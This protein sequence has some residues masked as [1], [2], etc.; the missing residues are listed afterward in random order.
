MH[1]WLCHRPQQA[2]PTTQTSH[3]WSSMSIPSFCWFL[4]T[5]GSGIQDWKPHLCQGSILPYTWSSKKLSNKFL[6]LMKSLHSWHPFC[7]PTTSGQSPCCTPSFPH[8]NVEPALQIQFTPANCCQWWT[9]IWNLRNPWLQDW[10]PTSCLQAIVSCLLDRYEA[11][12][13][14]ILTSEL[15]H[16]SKL[17]ADFHSVYPAK[18]G[19]L[20][21]LWLRCTSLQLKSYLKFSNKSN[22]LLLQFYITLT[23]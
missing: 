18:S 9:G 13:S 21:G 10:Q 5:S 2:T 15:R 19:P 14:W 3:C 23:L 7:H 20:S 16:A 4:M 11:D 8:L 12:T 17:V 6:D 1:S 22:Q